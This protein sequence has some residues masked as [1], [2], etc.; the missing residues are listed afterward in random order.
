VTRRA[1]A[2]WTALLAV[3]VLWPSHVLSSFD[4]IPL[5]GRAE[6]L[7]IGL[8]LPALW[9]IDRRFLAR[10]FAR[11]A[12]LALIAARLAAAMLPQQGLCARFS[13][14]APLRGTVSTI[15]VDEPAGILR[16]WDVRTDWR[17]ATPV[18]TA[19][20]DRAYRTRLEFP[21]WVLNLTG[22]VRPGAAIAF[23]VTGIVTAA[24]PA[25]LSIATGRD[26]TV[27]GLIG[28]VP[29][30]ASGGAD[31]HVSLPARTS[32]LRLRVSTSGDEW[33]FV[34]TIDGRDA[35][36]GGSLTA[37]APPGR[38]NLL[39]SAT[40]RAITVC[41]FVALL[42]GWMLSAVISLSGSRRALAFAAV[43]ACLAFAAG[44]SGTFERF[45][46]LALLTAAWVPVRARDRT[47]GAFVL[48]GVPW[49]AFVA[50]LGW[51]R[52][53]EV[54][55][56]SVAD[57]WQM[58]QA[59]AYR[60]ALNGYWLQGG[61]DT[62]YFQPLY[63]WVAALLHLGFGD[64]S[65]G[66]LYWDG[67]CLLAGAMVTFVFVHKAAGFRWA[68][69]G[70]AA[71]LATFTISPIWYF[72]G[73]GLSEITGLGWFAAASLCMMRARDGRR[74]P[75]LAAGLLAVLM[76][77]TRL[78]H[79]L[80]AAF[81][82]ACLLRFDTSARM[83][84]LLRA[85]AAMPRTPVA[86]Y[87]ATVAAGLVLFAA[88]TWYYAG[89][90]SLLYGTSYGLQRT[91]LAPATVASPA[92]WSRIAE[93]LAAQ[94]SMRE[95]PAFDLRAL[96]VMLGAALAVLALLQTPVLTG[97]PAP[98]V[99]LTVGTIAGSLFVHTHEYPGRMTVH[100]VPLAV[101]TAAC[102]LARALAS[103]TRTTEPVAAT[104]R[105]GAPLARPLQSPAAPARSS[106]DALPQ[107]SGA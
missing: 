44:R 12:I 79:L 96:P 1:T 64:A 83:R 76:I 36:A 27:A 91:G 17:A 60:I 90:F 43:G 8:V 103:R 92:V 63:R 47:R 97:L 80:L 31:V 6:A 52:M 40:L 39:A 106:F 5:R 61:S 51:S 15:A 57:D 24:P 50:G 82:P 94:L 100:V 75:A 68:L 65:I 105:A 55:I 102:T 101:A 16:S 72:I 73:R 13:T 26:M 49:L 2:A 78:N 14:T 11:A 38:W 10:R 62:F 85:V 69:A 34:P 42:A 87:A 74:A 89:H 28:D 107:G 71:T 30:S 86:I 21:A 32:A 35:I 9:A 77:Y 33:R 48:L 99:L 98:L 70:A 23:D 88:H 59:A 46:P 4:G 56:Y 20:F 18:C 84:T 54:T 41:G 7:A 67:V 104:D 22:A 45:V 58:Y 66:E 81:V 37:S 19:I 25:R 53:T 93:A 3:A 29:V 95:P